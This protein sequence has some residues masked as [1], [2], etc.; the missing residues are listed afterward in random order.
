MNGCGEGCNF[1][2]HYDLNGAKA[3][4]DILYFTTMINNLLNNAV[5]YSRNIPEVR[6]EALELDR[7]LGLLQITVIL[8][9]KLRIKELE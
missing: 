4:I 7:D 5:K 9:L 8:L 1:T 6:L 3:E 2:E